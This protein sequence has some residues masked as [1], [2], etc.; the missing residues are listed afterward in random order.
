MRA[1]V[2][3]CNICR[4]IIYQLVQTFQRCAF[5]YLDFS[6]GWLVSYA[7]LCFLQTLSRFSNFPPKKRKKKRKK[8]KKL[9]REQNER[10]SCVPVWEW[11]VLRHRLRSQR[12]TQTL[13]GL[14]AEA[15]RREE[16]MSA[17]EAGPEVSLGIVNVHLPQKYNASETFAYRL[18]VKPRCK[19]HFDNYSE[20]ATLF[21]LQWGNPKKQPCSCFLRS[22]GETQWEYSS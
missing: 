14:Q 12:E 7:F 2:R 13:M 4:G 1:S 20:F 19:A 17:A 15:T 3:C 22:K 16:V 10:V 9:S 5:S 11:M 18:I 6:W 8:R 21:P